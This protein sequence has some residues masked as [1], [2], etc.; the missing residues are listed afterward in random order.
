MELRL[1]PVT[2]ANWRHAVFLTTDPERKIPLDEKWLTSNAFSM[3]QCRYDSDWDCR[4][5]LDEDKAV[6]FV[7][8]GYW[9]EYDRYLLCR[10]MIDVQYQNLGY[11]KGFLPMVVNQI[12]VQYGCRDV[13]TS[14]HDDNP[15][16]K[17]LYT[18]FGFV[19]TDEMDAEER[20]YVLKG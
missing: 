1:E 16:A 10:Y 11:G 19:P 5:L 4:L 9:R 6:G 14:V 13:Y 3:L 20:V 12:R 18:G 8:Y 17:H 2:Q 7:F 15:V